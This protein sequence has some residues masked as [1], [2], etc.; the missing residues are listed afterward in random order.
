M[1]TK[2]ILRKI[3][4]T[5]WALAAHCGVYCQVPTDNPY[6]A[7]YGL[8]TH[9]SDSIAW[10]NAVSVQGVEGVVLPGN[11][12][13]SLAFHQLMEE[14]HQDG[15]GVI[16]FP[17]GI[18]YFDFDVSLYSKVVLRGQTPAESWAQQSAFKPPTHFAFP[19]YVARCSGSGTSNA[20][21]FKKITHATKSSENFGLVHLDINRAIIDFYVN[22][23]DK[24]HQN[25]LLFGVRQNNA[26]MPDPEFPSSI[27]IDEG[28]GW[29]RWPAWYKENVVICTK[30]Q[31]TVVNCRLNDSITDN[32]LQP[33]YMTNDGDIFREDTI[34]FNFA[35]HRGITVYQS[36]DSKD[37]SEVT[38]NYIVTSQYFDKVYVDGPA[39]TVA[40][41]VCIDTPPEKEHE[42]IGKDNYSQQAL[43][44]TNELFTTEEIDFEGREGTFAYK[45][46]TPKVFDK[47]K[48]Y[49][50][51]VFYH[52]QG[53]WGP[54][55][56]HTIHFVRLF[57]EASNYENYPCFVLIPYG[58]ADDEWL[59]RESEE[60]TLSMKYSLFLTKHFIDQE[61]ID[62]DRVYVSG[63]SVGANAAWQALLT[64]PKWFAAAVPLGAYRVFTN[65]SLNRIKRIPVWLSAGALDPHIPIE[66]MRLMERTLAQRDA[67]LTYKEY[68]DVGHFSWVPLYGD[69]TFLP[70]LFA[71][72]RR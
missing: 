34:A 1:S 16:F 37:V 62:K 64:H 18:Y 26:A 20:T 36:Q 55:E 66:Y 29:Q 35:Y 6:T 57:A 50:L 49:P 5:A 44:A 40:N 4:L 27:Q 67:A 32:F 21:A 24:Y 12:V 30:G 19:R 39:V 61:Y 71:Q 60:M 46:L 43:D 58:L 33:N 63:I 41:N 72:S 31:S 9:W 22:D 14:L 13:D 70:W 52:G 28:R 69:Q 45:L 54:D 56:N 23:F 7:Q 17:A 59:S 53:E 42:L 15:G 38:D 51:V 65:K 8:S 68:S 47:T 25:V 48:Q 10:T 2:T 3:I 11:K